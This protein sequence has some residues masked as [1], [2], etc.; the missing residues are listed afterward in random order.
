MAEDV[1]ITCLPDEVTELILEDPQLSMND[2]LSLAL[3]CKHLH[4][5]VLASGK[6]WRTKFFQ[7]Y[8]I[9]TRLFLLYTY[10]VYLYVVSIIIAP[11]RDAMSRNVS[12]SA[13]SCQVS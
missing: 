6:L 11:R 8:T 10:T 4:R 3:S 13:W 5:V 12:L 1:L 9:Y 7:R 2:V